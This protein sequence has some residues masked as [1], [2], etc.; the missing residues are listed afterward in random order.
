MAEPEQAPP[1]VDVRTP[2]MARMYDYA[3]GGKHNF[4]SDRATHAAIAPPA[5]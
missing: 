1:G 5:E 3:L 2:N 4:A